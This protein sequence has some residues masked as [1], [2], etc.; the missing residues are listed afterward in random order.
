MR[1]LDNHA[2][3]LYTREPILVI[4]SWVLKVGVDDAFCVV[5][6][7]DGAGDGFCDVASE[8]HY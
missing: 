1:S 4:A 8:G 5:I 6:V 7:Y 3:Y 2:A